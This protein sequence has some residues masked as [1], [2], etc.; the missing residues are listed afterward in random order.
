A[1]APHGDRHA[2]KFDLH[3]AES[4]E[5]SERASVFSPGFRHPK[6]IPRHLPAEPKLP[7]KSWH[8]PMS[9][10]ETSTRQVTR[11]V[12][13]LLRINESRTPRRRPKDRR[14]HRPFEGQ[15]G[16]S[17]R[18]RRKRL[19]ESHRYDPDPESTT[20]TPWRPPAGGW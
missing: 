20:R 14:G 7:A 4:E 9:R 2:H 13:F 18:P 15:S 10:I 11:A 3:L 19:H 1:D 8:S 17:T 6:F 16:Y 5:P 12:A